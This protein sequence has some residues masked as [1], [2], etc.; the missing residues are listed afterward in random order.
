[1][2]AINIRAKSVRAAVVLAIGG[3]AILT[4]S[5]VLGSG[6]RHGALP[7]PSGD[8]GEVV[9]LVQREPMTLA[10]MPIG[11]LGE[12]I[13]EAPRINV[14]V[15]ALQVPSG[16]LGEVVIYAPRATTDS[17]LSERATAMIAQR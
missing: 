16:D 10:A 5:L 13:V 2:N 1:M 8:L 17:E 7:I 3:A 12:V 6:T 15:A 9:V 11:D 4:G 14:Q